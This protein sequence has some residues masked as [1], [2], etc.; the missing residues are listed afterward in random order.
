MISESGLLTLHSL[1][2]VDSVNAILLL[3]L[4]TVVI[5]NWSIHLFIN[6]FFIALHH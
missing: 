1:S 6:S 4:Y 5:V 2:P 3:L